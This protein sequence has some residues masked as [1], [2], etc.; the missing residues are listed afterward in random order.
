MEQTNGFW[1][2]MRVDR[3]LF[4]GVRSFSCELMAAIMAKAGMRRQ[5]WRYQ[6]CQ[7]R[8]S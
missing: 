2:A 5:T 1:R 4:F 8:I 3:P 7:E 6:P